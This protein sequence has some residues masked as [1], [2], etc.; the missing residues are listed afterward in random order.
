MGTEEPLSKLAAIKKKGLLFLW[1]ALTFFLPFIHMFL[2]SRAQRCYRGAGNW[3]FSIL[4]F[5]RHSTC[6]VP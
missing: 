1:A 4:G 2:D 6:C 3:E 5:K